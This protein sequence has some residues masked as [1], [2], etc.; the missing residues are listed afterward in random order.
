MVAAMISLLIGMALFAL[1][2]VA[3][4]GGGGSSWTAEVSAGSDYSRR[5]GSLPMA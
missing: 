4:A 1:S 5:C 2:Y 3:H